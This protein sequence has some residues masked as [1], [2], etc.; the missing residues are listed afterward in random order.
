MRLPIKPML[1]QAS[2]SPSYGDDS[3]L[4]YPPRFDRDDVRFEVKWDGYRAIAVND[5]HRSIWSRPGR[6]IT[7]DWPELVSTMPDIPF[8]M[9]GEIV[10]FGHKGHSFQA[11]QNAKRSDRSGLRFMAFDLL[12][13][14][15]EDITSTPLVQRQDMLGNLLAG[16]DGPWFPSVSSTDGRAAWNIVLEHGLEGLISKPA[17]SRYVQDNRGIWQKHKRNV[18]QVFE[19]IGMTSGDGHRSGAFGAL[20]LGERIDGKVRYAGKCGTGFDRH[21]ISEVLQTLAKADS[22]SVGTAQQTIIRQRLAG[23]TVQWVKP[24]VHVLV[25]F[26]DWS[27]GRIVRM[28]AFKGFVEADHG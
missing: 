10:M 25:E 17:R 22:P 9:D 2:P 18:R 16:E 7:G 13:L 20:V 8:V 1:A 28:G 19:V 14:N 23:R 15:G 24:G 26:N 4:V 5:K 6:N 3:E 21:A 11:L 12:S 27:D